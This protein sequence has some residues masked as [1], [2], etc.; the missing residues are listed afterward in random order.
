[1]RVADVDPNVLRCASFASGLLLGAG[2]VRIGAWSS[3]RHGV[4]PTRRR[5]LLVLAIAG[6]ALGIGHV[7]TGAPDLPASHAAFLF[8]ANTVIAAA[9]LT[10]AVID[11]EHMI[12]P[13]E[14]TLGTAFV[15][16]ATSPLRAIGPV[17]S[18][19]GAAFGFAAAY[20]P[21]LLYRRL[22][23]RSGMGLGDAKLAIAAGAWH[24][25]EGAVFVLLAGALQAIVFALALRLA[26]RDVPVPA[27][28]ARE[29]QA[30]R[31]RAEAGDPEAHAELAADPMAT[32]PGGGTLGMRLPLGPFLA[33]ACVE[34]LFFRQSFLELL[35]RWFTH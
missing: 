18:G 8:G 22:R 24:G 13:N 29:I 10:A 3:V 31:E 19:L 33:L 20:L 34:L 5:T 30:L 9:I 28:V 2:F 32:D 12:L 7:L 14:L 23:R 35:A 6:V 16:L 27:S 25:P 4:A 21:F 17:A 26:G 11:A 1:M 15:A